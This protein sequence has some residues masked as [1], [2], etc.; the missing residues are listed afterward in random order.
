[1]FSTLQSAPS[2]TNRWRKL[3]PNRSIGDAILVQIA[4]KLTKTCGSE[5]GSSL[6]RHLTPQRKTAIWVHNYNPSCAQSRKYTLENLLPVWLSVRTNLFVPSHFWTTDGN[7][8]KRCVHKLSKSTYPSLAP[9]YRFRN[10]R[11]AICYILKE[12]LPC[13]IS[14]LWVVRY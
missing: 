1:M 14:F 9:H 6:W 12:F 8:D 4:T 2:Q 11:P 3:R 10:L 5:F 7:I 13:V